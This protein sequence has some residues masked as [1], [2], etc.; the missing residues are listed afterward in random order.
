MPTSHADVQIRARDGFP[1]AATVFE[2]DAAPGTV[3]VVAPA[4]G[5]PR[6]Y[7]GP[8]ARFL[9]RSGA[10]VLTFDY[11]GIAGS[12]PAWRPDLRGSLASFGRLD[13]RAVLDHAAGLPGA[14][15]IAV[16]AHSFGTT[17]FGL[18]PGSDRVSRVVSVASGSPHHRFQ[19]FPRDLLHRSWLMVGGSIP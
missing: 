16:L 4:L 9:A 2:G 5:V 6:K 14:R 17:A 7:Y 19:P 13:L 10:Q 3:V 15:E 8:F 12:G 11:R 18:A 1:L